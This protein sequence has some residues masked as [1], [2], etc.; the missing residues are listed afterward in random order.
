MLFRSHFASLRQESFTKTDINLTYS[1]AGDQLE[2]GLWVRNLENRNVHAAAA[3][4]GSANP[5]ITGAVF[6]EAPRT[7]GGRMVA[8]F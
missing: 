4:V 7:Y 1:T 2:F 3:E 5:N 6:L 8:K